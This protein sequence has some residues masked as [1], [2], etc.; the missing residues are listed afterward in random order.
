MVRRKQ[1]AP[2]RESE[3]ARKRRD[4]RNRILRELHF[5]GPLT[6]GELSRVCR[7]RKSSTT[8]IVQE[9]LK[10]GLVALEN[11][12]HARSP[13]RLAGDSAHHALVARVTAGVVTFARVFLDGRLD[14]ADRQV[15]RRDTSPA[16][17]L[18][19][20][21]DGFDR[22]R[23]ASPPLGFGLAMPGVID[24]VSGRVLCSVNL[25]GWEQAEPGTSLREALGA[26]VIVDNDVRTQLW[27][28]A[29]FD[30]LL[31]RAD[32]ILYIGILEG[33]A[34]AMIL[35]GRRVL[36]G[37]FRAGEIGHVCA[38]TE[39]RPCNCGK[40]DCLETYCGFGAITRDLARQMPDLPQP[41]TPEACAALAARDPA[42]DR[43]L[44]RSMRRL[45]RYV[46]GLVVAMDP[47]VVVLG[48]ESRAL[49]DVLAGHLRQH[50]D[51]ELDGL[52]AGDTR[53]RPADDAAPLTLRGIGGL[54]IE[55]A[56]RLGPRTA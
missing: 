18:P 14:I 32:N 26:P 36:G 15:L 56:F 6:R 40:R 12:S 22:L 41:F 11:P 31:H 24:P 10:A 50:L 39:G 20:L 29:W 33:I 52:E 23:A 2:A 37:R 16:R 13:I 25:Q 7:I 49:S 8:T 19:L 21:R 35:H 47:Q 34:C 44:D 42:V 55:Q 27:A 4:N 30:R 38:G 46:A 43:L 9:L 1:A 51:R 28:C 54:V 53:L 45:A 3:Q 48:S 17:V 5:R